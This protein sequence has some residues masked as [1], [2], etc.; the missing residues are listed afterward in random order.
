MTKTPAIP[1]RLA[2]LAT[3]YKS[4]SKQLEKSKVIKDDELA[5]NKEEPSMKAKESKVKELT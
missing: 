2:S 1:I 4:Q 3:L 5:N